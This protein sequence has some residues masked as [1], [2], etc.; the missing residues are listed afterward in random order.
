MS[1]VGIITFSDGRRHVHEELLPMNKSFQET[2]IKRLTEAGHTVIIADE[3]P[4][5]NPQAVAAGKKME[6]HS[7]DCTIFNYSIWSWPQ[8]TVLA[9]QFAP[10]PYLCLSNIN[11][12][13][14]GLVGMLASSGALDNIGIPYRRIS[15]NIEDETVFRRVN[16]FIRA[17]SCAKSLR[18]E[19]FGCFGGRPM[20]M[21]TATVGTETWM[22]VFGIDVE[23][24]DQWEIV[25]KA[26]SYPPEKIER[27]L[28][29]CEENIGKIAYDGK[30]LTPEILKRQIASYYAVRDLCREMHLDFCGIKGQ[31]ELTNS[32]CTMD[33]AEAFMN[34]PYDFDGP[35]EP[36]VCSTEADMDAGLTMEILKKLAN[37]P[38]LFADVRH[39]HED[40]GILDMCNS[41]QHATYFAGG[42]FD[43]RD[44]LSKVIF[45]PE[46]FYFPAGGATVHHLAHPGKVTLARL[47][48]KNGEYWMAI[49]TGEF[50]QY[51]KATNRTIMERTQL[52]WPHAFCKL[53]TSIDCFIDRFPCNHIHAVYGDYVEELK[54]VCEVIG[55][56]WEMI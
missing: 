2:L 8:F 6:R 21:Y 31:P 52:E 42:S 11:P 20:G 28:R 1:T 53:D 45:Y 25:R 29:W 48:R 39:W 15:G 18:G 55:I 32:F 43:Y 49:L 38:V 17:A 24:I 4:C 10:G 35:K 9:A 22:D 50:V 7:V 56:R 12:G 26:A 51:D 46:G 23:H 40:Y 14:P 30:Q 41:G 13:Y 27:A 5:T 54:M 34:D 3:I 44:N 19:T 33:V 16:L 36:I 37:T 47:G